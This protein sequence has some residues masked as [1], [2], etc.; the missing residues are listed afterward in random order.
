VISRKKVIGNRC[1]GGAGRAS[2][3]KKQHLSKRGFR[4]E[5]GPGNK[6][7]KH[8]GFEKCQKI[9]QRGTRSP[10]A[11]D[12]RDSQEEKKAPTAG[13]QKKIKKRWEGKDRYGKW[14]TAGEG[15]TTRRVPSFG[16]ENWLEPTEP[17]F[18]PDQTTLPDLGSRVK[19]G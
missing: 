4:G 18:S 9:I 3:Q 16:G 11:R 5:R 17:C 10:D 14:G 8:H 12:K 1:F 19:R 2:V 6:A 15:G 13:L 7:Y